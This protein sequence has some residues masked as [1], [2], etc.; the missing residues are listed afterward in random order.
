MLHVL[1]S[2]SAMFSC[3][4]MACLSA[5]S[6]RAVA[7]T[8]AAVPALMCSKF[9]WPGEA[10]ALCNHEA[11]PLLSAGMHAWRRG[12]QVAQFQGWAPALV[13]RRRAGRGAHT[14][15]YMLF[16]IYVFGC[17][18]VRAHLVF[19]CPPP[20][21]CMQPLRQGRLGGVEL[22]SMLLHGQSPCHPP[23]PPPGPVLT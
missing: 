6:R 19:V 9:Q 17:I 20:V 7:P 15:L 8:M 13:Q 1:I 10:S 4:R 22:I 2:H 14:Y 23:H 11:W 12:K 21:L 5:C 16:S 18:Y 3:F